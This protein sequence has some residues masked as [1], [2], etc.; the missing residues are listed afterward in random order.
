MAIT[1]LSLPLVTL[2]MGWRQ[3]LIAVDEHDLAARCAAGASIL[4]ALVTFGLTWIDGVRGA[5]LGVVAA[6]LIA[7]VFT[8]RAAWRTIGGAAAV[9]AVGAGLVA[10][11]GGGGVAAAGVR[12]G[13]SVGGALLVVLAP[14][15]TMG[16]LILLG[17]IDRAELAEVRRRLVGRAGR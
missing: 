13:I 3:L 7:A 1:S 17:A 4:G 15:V 2:Q 5:A 11:A 9:P 12:L 10:L 14:L 8:G 16:L 6:A